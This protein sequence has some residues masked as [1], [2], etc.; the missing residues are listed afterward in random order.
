ML[1][2]VA[3]N[4]IPFVER[5]FSRIGELELLDGRQI[6]ADS[7]KNADLLVCRTV[8]NIKDDLVAES[9]LR[10][11]ASPTSGLD[12][13]DQAS[14]C[15]RGI[16]LCHAPGRNARS[17]SEYVLSAL[18]V[19]AD[20]Q[21]FNLLDKKVG[22][23]G[24]GHVGSDLKKLL[25][26]IG[27]ECLVYDPL[28]QK[29]SKQQQFCELDDIKSCDVVSLHVPLT[30]SAPHPTCRMIGE[31]FLSGVS[32]DLILIN[33][34][35]GDVIDEAA[36]LNHAIEKPGLSLVIDVWQDEPGINTD[37]LKRAQIATPHIAGYS[38]D[39]KYRSTRD[40]FQQICDLIDIKERMLEKEEVFPEVEQRKISLSG[41]Q[42]D[43]SAIS[44]AILTSYDVRSD[45]A[46]LRRLLE[47]SVKDQDA[48][49][50]EL[51]NNYPIRREFSS[52]QVELID[53]ENSLTEKLQALG[54]PVNP[55]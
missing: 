38:I 24:C 17:V 52:L 6:S 23:I 25:E 45:A 12:H 9:G 13:I 41:Q 48:Y 39:A 33:T 26:I 14:L 30:K 50:A 8:T 44:M 21:A 27:L 31:D 34:S 3:D 54:F 18:C 4:A 11:I 16:E 10:F 40:V 5:F 15:T 20:Q 29:E 22:I 36:L 35:R 37:L 47:D 55:V 43:L 32:D 7:L 1:N 51:R 46:A 49:F 28:L 53:A 19:L 42:D 2:I